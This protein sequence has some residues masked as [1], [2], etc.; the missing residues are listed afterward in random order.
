MR[1]TS[2]NDSGFSS[3]VGGMELTVF[4]RIN[5]ANLGRNSSHSRPWPISPKMIK[6]TELK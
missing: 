1:E 6:K 5:R 3:L 2:K 4:K